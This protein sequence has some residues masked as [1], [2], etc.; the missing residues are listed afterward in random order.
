MTCLKRTNGLF[1]IGKRLIERLEM[2][3]LALVNDLFMEL[4]WLVY[5]LE[6]TCLATLNDLL[7]SHQGYFRLGLER[8][9]V[10]RIYRWP[11]QREVLS[12]C[13]CWRLIR[14]SF[15][16]SERKQEIQLA[17]QAIPWWLQG[18]DKRAAELRLC[19]QQEVR[20]KSSKHH[21][22]EQ[23]AEVWPDGQAG[24]NFNKDK[25]GKR[26]QVKENNGEAL[27][28]VT[29]LKGEKSFPVFITTSPLWTRKQGRKSNTM[30]TVWCP[31]SDARSITYILNCRLFFSVMLWRLEAYFLLEA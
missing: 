9:Q 30:T 23:P 14:A 20:F 18:M 24:L 2:T 3:Y 22:E 5:H 16:V 25:Q 11:S 15:P 8:W 31:R 28:Q 29:I 10:P 17:L 6:M 4:K 13:F 7:T 1:T 26:Q 19:L 21:R 27:P 12:I